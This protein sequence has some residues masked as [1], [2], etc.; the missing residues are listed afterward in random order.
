MERDFSSQRGQVGLIVL[1]TMTGMLTVG[2]SL[3]SRTTQEALIS[4]KESDSARV[5]NAAEQGVEQALSGGLE[6]VGDTYEGTVED[7]SGVDVNYTISKVNQ[8]E[9]RLFEGVSVEVNV[10]GAQDGNELQVNWSR[11]NDC[12][13]QTPASLIVS[14]Y[15]D[16]SGVTRVRHEALGG[17]D[18]G[19][20]FEL[21]SVVDVDGYKR[22]AN[23]VLTASD[24]LVRIKP[25]Y[26]DAHIRVSSTDFTMPAQY[27]SVRS[28]AENQNGDE[29]RVVEVNRTLLSA[30]S[31]FDYALYSGTDLNK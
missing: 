27:Y 11:E 24:F 14:V 12:D 30:P 3:A 16:D 2:L 18:R 9:T 22:Q 4:G 15:Y 1:L 13:T 10:T 8:L 20:G 7:V 25:V 17:C 6:F 28:Q 19:D 5:F 31:I 29:L 23:L 26:N 21:A